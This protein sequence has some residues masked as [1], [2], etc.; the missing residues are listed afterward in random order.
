MVILLPPGGTWY[1]LPFAC[2]HSTL[3][4]SQRRSGRTCSGNIQCGHFLRH[5]CVCNLASFSA[6]QLAKPFKHPSSNPSTQ[7]AQTLKGSKESEC[8]EKEAPQP[9]NGPEPPDLPLVSLGQARSR[10]S[11]SRAI[12]SGKREGF[13]V[14]Q[15]ESN[16]SQYIQRMIQSVQALWSWR[17]GYRWAGRLFVS[18][19]APRATTASSESCGACKPEV[20]GNSRCEPGLPICCVRAHFSVRRCYC[21]PRHAD[22]IPMPLPSLPLCPL[23]PL[24][25]GQHSGGSSAAQLIIYTR[26]RCPACALREPPAAMYSLQA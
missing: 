9:A 16:G 24:Y 13:R 5:C 11:L 7:N 22:S 6:L 25:P 8:A 2:T 4:A 18:L 19:V 23:C 17:V 14:R 12:A 10:L 26:L 20:T 21:L 3:A 15:S 1:G